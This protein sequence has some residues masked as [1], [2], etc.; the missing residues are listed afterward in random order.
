MN[1]KEAEL[2]YSLG[3]NKASNL[4]SPVNLSLTDIAGCPSE[5]PQPQAS[6]KWFFRGFFRK[7]TP[8]PIALPPPHFEAGGT[9]EIRELP[10][11][12]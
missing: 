11:T 10:R 9:V 3:P 5:R 8:S 12:D 1:V 6:V 7:Q 2:L 4:S